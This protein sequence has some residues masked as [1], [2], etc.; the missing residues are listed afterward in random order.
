M[1]AGTTQ[2]LVQIF[3][4]LINQL[5]RIEIKM[6]LQNELDSLELC[7]LHAIEEL[8]F[9]L[10]FSHFIGKTSFKFKIYDMS[11]IQL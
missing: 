10:K 1:A 11:N 6:T 9:C 7:I 8:N 2:E 4:L 5:N 3:Y